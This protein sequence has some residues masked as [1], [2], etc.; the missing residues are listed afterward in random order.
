MIVYIYKDLFVE[1]NYYSVLNVFH[2]NFTHIKKRIL[3]HIETS[4]RL[5]LTKKR[6]NVYFITKFVFIVSLISE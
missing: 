6:L 2:Q 1:E 3:Y 5:G 4:E